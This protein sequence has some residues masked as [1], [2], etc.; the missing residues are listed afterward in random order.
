MH[1]FLRKIPLLADLSQPDLEQLAQLVE[2][3]QLPAGVTLFTEGSPGD[4]AYIIKEGQIDILTTSAGGDLLLATRTA[5]EVIG[6][7]ALLDDAPRQASAWVKTDSVLVAIGQAEFNH[8]LDNSSAAMRTILRLL[9]SRWRATEAVLRQRNQE[10]ELRQRETQERAAELAM[11][12]HV[13]Q[14]LAAQLD[15]VTL[16]QLV[17]ENIRQIF[18]AQIAYVA[19]YDR[20][21]GLIR[22][23]YEYGET[24][25]AIPFGQGLSS[26][27]IETGQPLLI[28]EDVEGRHIELQAQAVGIQPKSFLGVPI[29]IGSEVIGVIGVENIEREGWFNEADLRLLSTIA[30]NVGAAIHNARLYTEAET[31]RTA[32]ERANQAKSAF[33][34]NMNHELRTPL[35]AIVGFTRIVR[36]KAEGV[37][38]EKQVEN[39]DKVL[40]SADHLLGLINTVLDIAKIEAGRV[41]VQPTTFDLNHLVM[42][43]TNTVQPLLKPGVTLVTD[44]AD[45]LPLVYSD[46]DKIKQI[47][48]NLL[49]NAAKFTH[50]GNITVR[51]RLVPPP[52]STESWAVSW[53]TVEVSDTGIGIAEEAINRIF[54]EFQQA[55]TSTTRQ[56]GGTGLGLAISRKLAQLLGGRLSAA[57]TAGVGS[58]FSLTLPLQ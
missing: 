58:T 6:E 30:A 54:E 10:L 34:A 45:V 32:A 36:R 35:N 12:H 17:G 37:L 4:R 16:I 21:A 2:V 28:N 19:L 15:L 5:G 1:E 47:L 38:P 14:A 56:Y 11:V 27:I 7:M 3:V 31:A 33:L 53:L 49:S 29:T 57:S 50:S 41:D 51:T 20:E 42:V 40:M 43:C 46:P 44:L 13:S 22:F 8:L 23:P 39:L 25:H 26:K 18:E 9:L 24:H 55:D 52:A 48:L